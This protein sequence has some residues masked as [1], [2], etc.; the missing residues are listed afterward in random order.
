MHLR[1]ADP[2]GDLRLGHVLDEAQLQDQA[3][4]LVEVG[5]GPLQRQ[6]VLDQL[7][8]LV[9][10]A[11][12]LRGRRFFLLAADRPVERE[13]APV[14]VGLQHL[15]HVGRVDLELAR[16]SRRPRASAAAR[17]VSSEIAFSTSAMRSCRPRGT[18]T[19]QTRS[20]KWRFSSPRMVGEAKAVKGVPRLGVE[21]VDRVDEAEAGDLQEVV[22]GL[23]GAAVAQRQVLGEGQVAAHQLLAGRLVAV[24]RRSAPRARARWPGRRR[25]RASLRAEV[26]GSLRFSL[27]SMP[28]AGSL[29][30]RRPEG[31]DIEAVQRPAA[32]IGRRLHTIAVGRR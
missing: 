31:V 32:S 9:L 10:V 5:E 23:A 21:A 2:L 17:T 19:V 20:R 8:A 7:E 11:D 28:R 6:L 25:G 16:R 15:E 13:R 29:H 22:E 14:V 4:A 26:V 24:A 12:P 27:P 1:V 3:L 30:R 18:R